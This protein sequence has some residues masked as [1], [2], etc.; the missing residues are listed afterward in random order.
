MASSAGVIFGRPDAGADIERAA[1][2][3]LTTA[4]WR[5]SSA[6]AAIFN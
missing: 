1:L 5:D 4:G 3:A 2:N 6:L